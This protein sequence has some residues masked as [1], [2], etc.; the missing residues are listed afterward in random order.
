V[1]ATAETLVFVALFVALFV[2]APTCTL[3]TQI[4]LAEHVGKGGGGRGTA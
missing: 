2:R 3:S 1:G 4:T